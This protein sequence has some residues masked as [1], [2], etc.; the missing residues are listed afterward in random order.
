MDLENYIFDFFAKR[1]YRFSTR[2]LRTLLIEL[3]NFHESLLKEGISLDKNRWQEALVA[4]HKLLEGARKK[5]E[6]EQ[7]YYDSIQTGISDKD[8]HFRW[9]SAL[10]KILPVVAE[11]KN[12]TRSDSEVKNLSSSLDRGEALESQ[13]LLPSNSLLREL[14]WKSHKR[15]ALFKLKRMPQT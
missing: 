3:E 15:G 8:N 6:S 13:Y 7:E 12:V 10:A 1:T 5:G 4:L 9:V 14:V 2:E 11:Y